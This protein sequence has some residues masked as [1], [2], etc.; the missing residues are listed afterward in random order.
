MDQFQCPATKG[1]PAAALQPPQQL[2]LYT[3]RSYTSLAR[4]FADIMSTDRL[5]PAAVY[6]IAFCR[7]SPSTSSPACPE[8]PAINYRV[9]NRSPRLNT[10]DVTIVNA[11]ILTPRPLS[12]QPVQTL[13]YTVYVSQPN[14]IGL[15]FLSLLGLH[16][17]RPASQS[18]AGPMRNPREGT[19]VM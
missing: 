19:S 10:S 2:L 6:A 1:R 8:F 12:I 11:K 16:T 7:L 18:Q 17:L 5:I 14:R 3:G 13:I 15:F 4:L 9:A